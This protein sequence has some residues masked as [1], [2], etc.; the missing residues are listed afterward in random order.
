MQLKYLAFILSLSMAFSA[1]ANTGQGIFPEGNGRGNIGL[2]TLSGK[3]QERV[4]LPKYSGRN[5]WQYN[6]GIWNCATNRKGNQPFD[7][8]GEGGNDKVVSARGIENYNLITTVG[9]QYTF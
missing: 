2:G 7:G 8:Y 1:T 4:Y 9:V 6:E 5:A 3:A